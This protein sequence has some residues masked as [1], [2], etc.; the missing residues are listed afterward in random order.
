MH[1]LHNLSSFQNTL[2]VQMGVWAPGMSQQLTG[3]LP[4]RSYHW[5]SV[6]QHPL[7]QHFS[8]FPVLIHH[9]RTLTMQ[10]LTK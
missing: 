4:S 9:L 1:E 8:S 3:Q 6:P 7:G 5:T 10:I 2:E